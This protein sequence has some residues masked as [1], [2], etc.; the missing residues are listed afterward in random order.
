M[1]AYAKAN[2]FLKLIGFDKRSYHLLKSR[3]ILIEDLFDELLI[4]N[5]KTQEGFELI[6]DFVCENN[7]IKKA[8]NLLCDYGYKN[9]L[10]E[11]FKNQSLKLIKN[12]PTCAGL[13]GGSSDAASFLLMMNEK[14][15]L[16]IPKEKLINLSLQLGSDI[17]FFLSGCK[18]ANVSGCGEIIEEFHDDIPN[19]KFT[20]PEIHCHTKE[21]YGQFDKT[22]FNFSKNFK[23]ANNY[24][25][26]S[27][28]EL[29]ENFDNLKL[30]DL[31]TPCVILYPK[32][33]EYLINGFF[34]SGSGSSVF[35]VEK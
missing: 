22:S 14:L 29:L 21:V 25:K 32:M 30:N 19:L 11:F 16:K 26:L 31:F 18:S 6:S 7:I 35:K 20:F 4:I 10:E 33:E 28:K 8:Y 24:E 15:N 13:G 5:Q 34:L 2:I 1:K 23:E 3:F 12:I 27:T 17:A 9:E